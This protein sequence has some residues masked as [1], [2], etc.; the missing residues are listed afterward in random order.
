MSLVKLETESDEAID[1]VYL[2]VPTGMHCELAVRAAKAGKHVFCEAP[3]ANTIED[4]RAIAQAA[5]KAAEK[6]VVFHTGLQERTNPQ[7]HHVWKF[8][9]TGVLGPNLTTCKSQ[10]NKSRS[11]LASSVRLVSIRWTQQRGLSR[12][13]RLLSPALAR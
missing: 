3:I 9:T 6:G 5:K 11:A 13:T 12:V 1:I 7:H 2:A 10:W 4:A 8:V